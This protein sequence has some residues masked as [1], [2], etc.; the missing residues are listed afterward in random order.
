VNTRKLRAWSAQLDAG[1]RRWSKLFC[2]TAG[3]S[4]ASNQPAQQ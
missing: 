2:E 1:G 4:Q 3:P